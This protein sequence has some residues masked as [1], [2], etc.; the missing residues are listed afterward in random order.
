MEEVKKLEE[1][2]AHL[3]QILLKKL[4]VSVTHTVQTHVVRESTALESIN[5]EFLP[6]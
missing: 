4:H 1:R 6:L 3:V 2:Q 5:H